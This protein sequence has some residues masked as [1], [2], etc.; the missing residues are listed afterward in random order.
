MPPASFWKSGTVGAKEGEHYRF[1]FDEG[2]VEHF[3]ITTE[4]TVA[5]EKGTKVKRKVFL[6]AATQNTP[7]SFSVHISGELG[8]VPFPRHMALMCR[9]L[10]EPTDEHSYP[11]AWHER[12][13]DSQENFE[14]N[15][16]F[17][18]LSSS[19]IQV[20]KRGTKAQ[21]EDITNRIR[22]VY[23]SEH[24][25]LAI[26]VT[27][28]EEPAGHPFSS[29]ESKRAGDATSLVANS[30]S[31]SSASSPSSLS[32]SGQQWLESEQ[33]RLGMSGGGSRLAVPR[34]GES[35]VD[36]VARLRRSAEAGNE[37]AL[38]QINSIREKAEVELAEARS[39]GQ[40]QNLGAMRALIEMCRIR[41]TGSGSSS[42]SS[43]GSSG[44][45]GSTPATLRQT[46][47]S[48]FADVL[49][50]VAPELSHWLQHPPTNQV[51]TSEETVEH[52]KKNCGKKVMTEEEA[53]ALETC[54][55]CMSGFAVGDIATTLPTCGHVFHL[56][57]SGD[58]LGLS[59][60]L[61]EHDT[62]PICRAEIDV[63][64][65]TTT[66]T[67]SADTTTTTTTITTAAAPSAKK[68]A[69]ARQMSPLDD[70]GTYICGA[71]Y[72]EVRGPNGIEQRC[73]LCEGS[74]SASRQAYKMERGL[75]RKVVVCARLV[76]E[77]QDVRCP[78]TREATALQAA[79][80]ERER[81]LSCAELKV[82]I[83]SNWQVKTAVKRILTRKGDKRMFT[84]SF[85]QEHDP[86]T[87][88][89][90]KRLWEM[91]LDVQTLGS[92]GGINK[93]QWRHFPVVGVASHEF[94]Q[95]TTWADQNVL[96]DLKKKN[97]KLKEKK[98][99]VDK[100][101]GG[102]NGGT[103]EGT[104][105]TTSNLTKMS[106]S[107]IRILEETVGT[108][109][110][111]GFT[112]KTSVYDKK[113]LEIM[114][115]KCLQWSEK[116]LGG[117]LDLCRMLVLTEAG[118]ERWGASSSSSSSSSSSES[119]ESS[120]A[121]T[122]TVPICANIVVE[123]ALCALSSTKK[124]PQIMALRFLANMCR[125]EKLA[126]S[127]ASNFDEVSR[128]VE[129]LTLSDNADSPM[130]YE[131]VQFLIRNVAS[132][133]SQEYVPSNQRDSALQWLSCMLR[134]YDGSMKISLHEVSTSDKS[135][136]QTTE[137]AGNGATTEAAAEKVG[138]TTSDVLRSVLADFAAVGTLLCSMEK[139]SPYVVEPVC[140]VTQSICDWATGLKETAPAKTKLIE[141]CEDILQK[142]SVVEKVV[143]A[144]SG[145][146][147]VS[148][149]QDD[150]DDS[151]SDEDDE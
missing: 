142:C 109:K 88:V 110:K 66:G 126:R 48:D 58:C 69:Q 40:T 141:C 76:E 45:S 91:W 25:H 63:Q 60:W 15:L 112:F 147:D 50:D 78:K 101:N 117:S 47:F 79:R 83:R 35:P 17:G 80:D 11:W 86:N 31:S 3:A 43:S 32:S 102:T 145:S 4:G 135:K 115:S 104:T 94:G 7:T 93:D 49:E 136:M 26:V 72:V 129:S 16:Q 33:T 122:W 57:P 148:L 46:S 28:T 103:N 51:V 53:E 137:G 56:C 65:A 131:G 8:A 132:N 139:L 52:M 62:C 120:E 2:G 125:K 140:S 74:N 12:G 18:L 121:A 111:S 19:K 82:A 133:F 106:P 29:P 87:R 71:C 38:D 61:T 59:Q 42:S 98:V 27:C 130:I 127:L 107:D 20:L 134:Y 67:K 30:S 64:S 81:L 116:K 13:Y 70:D 114:E 34:D 10:G 6:G 1:E 143:V 113:M 9:V 128:Q 146:N 151:D 150:S 24:P 85:Y 68:R 73:H 123:R 77:L 39:S 99:V 138:P 105:T 144:S 41:G 119:K 108:L 22:S 21:A 96:S 97:N 14:Q 37:E 75:F 92:L 54:C 118:E 100:G 124:L 44:G 89:V 90:L 84:E 5:E 55:V 23:A 36:M 95:M 149:Y